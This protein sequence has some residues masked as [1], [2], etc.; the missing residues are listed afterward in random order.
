MPLAVSLG[1]RLRIR[2]GVWKAARGRE[3]CPLLLVLDGEITSSGMGD[4]T[5]LQVLNP[6]EMRGSMVV[7][8][9]REGSVRK[10]K[11]TKTHAFS[12]IL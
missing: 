4:F 9:A 11:D 2:I 8:R 7:I 6:I 3:V 5:L 1:D 12:H 10:L